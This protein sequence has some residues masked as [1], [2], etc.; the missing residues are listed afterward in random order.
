MIT[1]TF[2][3][4]FLRVWSITH[5]EKSLKGKMCPMINCKSRNGP[6]T[7]ATMST[8][9]GLPPLPPG[10]QDHPLVFTRFCLC[11]WTLS[12]FSSVQSLSR[13]WLFATPWT[14]AHQA[15]LSITNSRTPPRLMSIKSVM[16]SNHLILYCPLLPLPPAPPTCRSV[17]PLIF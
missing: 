13:V 3:L 11:L 5:T 4:I 2:L 17:Y 9:V 8:R 16:P 6:F 7:H 10:P 14:A 15:S 1:H 12:S